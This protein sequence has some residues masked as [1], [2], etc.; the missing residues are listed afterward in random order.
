[1]VWKRLGVPAPPADTAMRAAFEEAYERARAVLEPKHAVAFR[2]IVA[3]GERRVELA[4]GVVFES[5][6]LA[7]LAAGATRLAAMAVTVGPALDALADEY[8]ANG[9]V[10]KMT[11][12]DAVGSA[13][14]EGLMRALHRD[15]RARAEAEGNVVTRRIS[16]GFGD[17]ALAAQ[18]DLLDVVRGRR[19]GI[20]LTANYMMVPR[21]SVT[22]VAAVKAG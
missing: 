6:T 20:T 5:A 21:K 10:F 11:V 3:V 12:A 7:K 1:M 19:L 18:P 4:S 8:N 14:A 15:V 16:P 17:F 13:A 9:E 2:R 22:A